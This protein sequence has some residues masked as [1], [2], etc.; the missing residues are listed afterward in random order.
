MPPRPDSFSVFD[1]GSEDQTQLLWLSGLP[2][3]HGGFAPVWPS[4]SPFLPHPELHGCVWCVWCDSF[5]LSLI[6]K[7]QL[8]RLKLPCASLSSCFAQGRPGRLPPLPPSPLISSVLRGS[9]QCHLSAPL[10]KCSH[11]LSYF[12]KISRTLILFSECSL[13]EG[14]FVLAPRRRH[15][16]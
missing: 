15:P 13:F 12:L 7:L 1:V 10:S 16:L 8:F 6:R 4:L 9:L 5:P 2:S 3:P 14:R 11:L